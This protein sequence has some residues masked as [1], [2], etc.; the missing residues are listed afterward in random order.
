M[1]GPRALVLA[2]VFLDGEAHLAAG[3]GQVEGVVEAQLLQAGEDLVRQ[4]LPSELGVEGRR[5][6][7][8]RVRK[9]VSSPKGSV[10]GTMAPSG[11][12]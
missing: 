6:N 1:S 7:G 4:D 2:E 9:R 5:R 11:R 3:Q 10:R 8:D 12:R